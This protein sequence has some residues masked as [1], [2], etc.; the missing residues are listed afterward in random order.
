MR[1]FGSLESSAVEIADH[2]TCDRQRLKLAFFEVKYDLMS[3]LAAKWL[4]FLISSMYI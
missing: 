1:W 2:R 4:I 3:F